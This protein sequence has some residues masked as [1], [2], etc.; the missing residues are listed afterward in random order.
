MNEMY[1]KHKLFL[2]NLEKTMHNY[3]E[4]TLLGPLITTEVIFFQFFNF[5]VFFKKNWVFLSVK[6]C[7]QIDIKFV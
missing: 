6:K 3:N 2:E 5:Y 4:N 1:E 7:I